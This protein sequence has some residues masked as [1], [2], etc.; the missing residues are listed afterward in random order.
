[1]IDTK[2]DKQTGIIINR[3]R[4]IILTEQFF[5]IN[6]TQDVIETNNTNEC[7]VKVVYY[8]FVLLSIKKII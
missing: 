6:L 2:C 7:S 1:M 3:Y 5:L 8:V 4:K